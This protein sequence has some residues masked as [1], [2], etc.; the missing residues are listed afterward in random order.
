MLLQLLSVLRPVSNVSRYPMRYNRQTDDRGEKELLPRFEGHQLEPQERKVVTDVERVGWS[1]MLVDVEPEKN[2]PGWA[3]TIGLFESYGHP[4]VAI[5]GLDEESR[6]NI[7]NW[8]GENAKEHEPL[9]VGQEHD[10]VLDGH[11]CWSREVLK[12]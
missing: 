6:Y 4:E 10:W 8:I 3:F 1:I 2:Q 12:C 11:P 9:V 7:L 5:F